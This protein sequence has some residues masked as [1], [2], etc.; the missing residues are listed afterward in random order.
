MKKKGAGRKGVIDEWNREKTLFPRD[1]FG[2]QLP[3]LVPLLGKP[4]EQIA[5]MPLTIGEIKLMK[6]KQEIGDIAY[7]EI[8]TYLFERCLKFPK[9]DYRYLKPDYFECVW[10]TILFECGFDIS[11]KKKKNKNLLKRLEGRDAKAKMRRK[12]YELIKRDKDIGLEVALLHEVG[13]NWFNY[14]N[15]TRFEVE[16]ALNSKNTIDK[17][18]GFGG[19][20]GGKKATLGKR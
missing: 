12:I 18:R 4:D 6:Y 15:L 8:V 10:K 19:K 13:Y 16:L 7:L 3:A 20:K 11:E 9:L 5:M 17:K 2:K 1:S 14:Y